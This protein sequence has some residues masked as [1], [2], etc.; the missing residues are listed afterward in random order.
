[1]G[2]RTRI[3]ALLA[4]VSLARADLP[5]HCVHDQVFGTWELQFSE[6]QAQRQMCGY[7]SPDQNEQHFSG[8]NFSLASARKVTVDVAPPALLSSRT[9]ESVPGMWSMV[10]DEGLFFDIGGKKAFAYFHYEPAKNGL[11]SSEHPG[12][13]SSCDRTRVGWFHEMDPK[14][15]ELMF[16]CFQGRM[17]RRSNPKI[18]SRG[19]QYLEPGAPTMVSPTSFVSVKRQVDTP[20]A[21]FRF[22]R[23]YI[24]EINSNAASTWTAHPHPELENKIS[25]GDAYRML[26]RSR[27]S[28]PSGGYDRR[29]YDV[30]R[31]KQQRD[32]VS[33][34]LLESDSKTETELPASFDWRDM[35]Q[36]PV[37]LDQGACGS[38]Y[39]VSTTSM[40]STRRK[41]ALAKAQGRLTGRFLQHSNRDA[42]EHK[43]RIAIDAEDVLSPQDVLNCSP[44]N[45]GC[46]GGYPFLVGWEAAR[47]GI[48]RDRDERYRGKDV[49]GA[50]KAELSRVKA[51]GFGYVGGHYG[52]GS[53]DALMR[54]I[55]ENG[56]ATVG[57][58]A[59]SN[60]FTYRSGVFQCHKTK[61]EGTNLKDLRPWEAT[62][63]AV[64]VYGWGVEKDQPY[65]L[66]K[67]SWGT[68]WGENGFF[69]IPRDD[70]DACA[71]LSM[72]VGVYF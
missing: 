67:N 49:Q 48:A 43:S 4:L 66:L 45:Q 50:C 37:A 10:Y 40:I 31:V 5:I 70:T 69:K 3:A 34:V 25:L 44:E 57:L 51:K 11:G 24:Q 55:Y 35:I 30:R 21:P 54:D 71:V 7:K 46:E 19:A 59:P 36:D 23:S 32:V 22:N 72:P 17:T 63:H 53:N 18:S 29:S 16:G 1:M 64:L 56:P 12:Y 38:C 47:F 42:G 9:G 6:S 39:S 13:V 27:F 60:L 65:W 41:I 26:G 61:H 28:K 33:P 62:N 58:D 68:F 52:A 8:Y 20:N 2:H 15:G 14:S